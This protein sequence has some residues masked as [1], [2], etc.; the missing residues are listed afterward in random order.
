M[1]DNTSGLAANSQRNQALNKHQ[2][3]DDPTHTLGVFGD[4]HCKKRCHACSSSYKN[5]PMVTSVLFSQVG[6]AHAYGLW[7]W[8]YRGQAIPGACTVYPLRGLCKPSLGEPALTVP[9]TIKAP[10]Q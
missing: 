5:S 2:L 4:L 1:K 9:N 7:T 8:P 6:A 10:C 3:G